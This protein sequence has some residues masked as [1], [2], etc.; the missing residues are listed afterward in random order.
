M[1]RR[2]HWQLNKQPAVKNAMEEVT[3]MLENAKVT[4]KRQ[5]RLLPLSVISA[6]EEAVMNTE[7][8]RYVRSYAWYRLL[9]VWGAMRYHDTL[10]VD[11]GSIKLD[12]SGLVCTLKRTKTTGPETDYRRA[13]DRRKGG[14]SRPCGRLP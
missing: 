12:E 3:L 10:G 5:A 13:D 14:G 6:M 1:Q 9:K 8:A 4:E 7:L 2:Y 11:F